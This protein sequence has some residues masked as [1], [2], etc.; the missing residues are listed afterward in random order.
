MM[1]D[2]IINNIKQ[3]V[4]QKAKTAIHSSAQWM[5]KIIQD[6]CVR[7]CMECDFNS[8]DHTADTKSKLENACR[9]ISIID[10]GKDNH[11]GCRLECVGYSFSDWSQQQL[12]LMKLIMSNSNL[13]YKATQRG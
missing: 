9:S 2:G 13:R 12:G 4:L 11:I 5:K 3:Q 7:I 10:S 8:L 1:A 6:E